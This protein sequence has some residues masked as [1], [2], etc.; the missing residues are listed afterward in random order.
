MLA[1]RRKPTSKIPSS[2]AALAAAR[3]AL[4]DSLR[5]LDG[6]TDRYKTA[7]AADDRDG[8]I[9]ARREEGDATLER[10]LATARVERLEA[11]LAQARADEAE[12]ERRVKYEAAK[13]QRDATA[14]RLRRDYSRIARELSA[15]FADI[16]AS[17]DAVKAAN[18]DKPA[19]APDLLPAESIVR[20][21]AGAPEK[22]VKRETVREWAYEETGERVGEATGYRLSQSNDRGVLAPP[23]GGRTIPVIK[24]PFDRV[25]YFPAQPPR[26]AD[27]LAA[28]VRLPGLHVDDAAIYPP[29]PAARADAAE[30]VP[31]IRYERA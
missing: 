4:E 5:R 22:I 24:R 23:G 30:P 25:T 19:D 6:A 21:R 29:E 12:A 31:E 11:E 27:Q 17:D 8:A 14:D 7:L 16:A 15:I 1:L 28:T 18:A 13:K 10:D 9:A 26:F 2:E 20:N 3:A